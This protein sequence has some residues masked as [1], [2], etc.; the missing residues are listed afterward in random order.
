MTS[1]C[2]AI[3]KGVQLKAIW[4]AQESKSLEAEEAERM[5]ELTEFMK[6]LEADKLAAQEEHQRQAEEVRTLLV[7]WLIVPRSILRCS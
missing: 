1:S 5:E 7:V 2:R 6:R 4:E 3:V